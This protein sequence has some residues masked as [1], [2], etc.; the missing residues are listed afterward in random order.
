MA[1]V[2]AGMGYPLAPNVTNHAFIAH[3]RAT[4]TD[5]RLFSAT[6]L[7]F[8]AGLNTVTSPPIPPA[9]YAPGV[10]YSFARI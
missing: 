4:P 1:T 8:Y 7:G 9:A 10:A 3:L 6:I 5:K 2:A